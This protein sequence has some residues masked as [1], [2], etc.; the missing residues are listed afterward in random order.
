MKPSVRIVHTWIFNPQGKLLICKRPENEEAFPGVW[1]SSAGGHVEEG[2][3]YKEAAIRETQEELGITVEP[4]HAFLLPYDR[5]THLN[6][7]DLWFCSHSGE[8][9]TADPREIAEM[10][11]VSMEELA[12]EMGEEPQRFNPEFVAMVRTWEGKKQ[13]RG[14]E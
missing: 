4:E 7:I 3:E 14:S 11:F 12:N 8:E 5:G 9:L 1:T 10:R 6:L 13:A 2:E